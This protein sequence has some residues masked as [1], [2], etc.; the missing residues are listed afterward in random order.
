MSSASKGN[1]KNRR[2]RGSAEGKNN[3]Q[4][5]GRSGPS[6]ALLEAKRRAMKKGANSPKNDIVRDVY[7]AMHEWKDSTKKDTA[8]IWDEKMLNHKALWDEGYPECPN[9][10][11]SVIE[12]CT[13]L[14]LLSR[15]ISLSPR[16]A[17]K[18]EILSLHSKSHLEKLASTAGCEDADLL[19]KLSSH[20]DAI[21]LH[22]TTYEA[23]LLAAGSAIE[24]VNSIL[25][26]KVQNGM[27]II[28]PPGHHAMKSEY[29]GYCF[30]NNVALGA[31][32]AL[33]HPSK[34]VSRV[35]IVDW[36]VH[37]GQATQQMFYK[38]PRVLYFSIHRYEYGQFWPN[39]AES[40]FEYVGEG[41][42]RGFN[43][44][45]PL[46]KTGMG[47]QDYFAI[48]RQVLM[49]VA[50]EF[51]PDLVLVS[52]GYDAAIGCPEGEMEVTPAFYA[53]LVAS[54]SCLAGGKI[55]VVLEG[56]YCLKSLA[57]GASLTLRALLGDPCPLVESLGEPS[58]S[59]LETIGYVKE[60]HAP[61]WASLSQSR[62]KSMEGVKLPDKKIPKDL[63][64]SGVGQP[65]YETRNCYPVQPEELRK[66]LDAR[67][68][69]L[70]IG[71]KLTFPK[72]RVCMVYDDRMLKHK[73]L[74]DPCHPERPD[75][76]SACLNRIQE[77]GL[78]DRCFQLQGRSAT[79]E[80]LLLCH[81]ESYIE[82]VKR[83]S[84]ME[85]KEMIRQEE[86]LQSI[87]IHPD[88]FE[89]A[90]VA[91]GSVLEVIDAVLND[92]SLRGVCAVR[93]PGHHAESDEACGFCFFNNAAL[94]ASYAV[95]V[96][97][98]KRILLV[99]WDVH[100][101]NGTQHI[102]ESEPRV[103][104]VS[105]HRYDNGSFFPSSK[106][107]NY[108]VVG[109]GLG[110]GFNVNIPWNK[111]GV[112]D[113][114]YLTAFQHVILP[115]AYEYAPELVIISAGFDAAVGDPLGG[116]KV[117]PEGYAHMASWLST[118]ANGKIVI[119][120]EGGYNITSTSLSFVACTKAL[121]GDPLPVLNVATPCQPH[122]WQ[123]IQNV[124]K[125]QQPYWS[126]LQEFTVKESA[127]SVGASEADK[128]LECS[129]GSSAEQSD[130][131]VVELELGVARDGGASA[132]EEEACGAVGGDEACGYSSKSLASFLQMEGLG[133]AYAVV[134]LTDCPHLTEV[135]DVPKDG[136]DCRAPCEQCLS[137]EENW[138]CLTCY[139]VLCGRYI[140]EHMMFHGLETNH[141]LT[142]GISDLS[143]WCYGCEAYIDNPV[144]Y[145]AKN[146]V[147]CSKFGYDIPHGLNHMK[148]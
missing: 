96:H 117:T 140:K 129:V 98:L 83:S 89:S 92:N 143:V 39:L 132:A 100:H 60:V 101:G 128:E 14:G 142:L 36:D 115:I 69:S 86:D 27:A 40:D 75:R 93:P 80:E 91:A 49:P 126:C 53:H 65:V 19:E 29:C 3:A 43:M 41:K 52:A 28:R 87:Y 10:L 33:N 18:E 50:Y 121:L 4:S 106:D 110:R 62:C 2:S 59:I 68:D 144:L 13:S 120:L 104:Y 44:N 70:I 137:C 131:P 127:Y 42:G 123:S 118:L 48:F 105:L 17:T 46:N 78:Y 138:V 37:H 1:S 148:N 81:T 124:I 20:Y 139:V 25:D 21:Y 88:S 122:A 55:G 85:R 31:L 9:R 145:D 24:L 71:T 109:E 134:P 73:N 108:S 76:L 64:G 146:S 72:E 133:E 97:G 116:C 79:D 58:Q 136:I 45:I 15:C 82:W 11:S 94:A 5:S 147:H 34:S 22:P 113:S 57:E 38:D 102:F 125:A 107:A 77:Y 119:I 114:E 67:L 56:G 111:R 32:H 30:L 35:L 23:S 84:V 103:L 95:K 90:S 99:D 130:A 47:N 7:A 26:R 141:P 51:Q 112:G 135:A 66:A 74:R 8:V 63:P 54:L 61:F 6:A 12:R 16:E